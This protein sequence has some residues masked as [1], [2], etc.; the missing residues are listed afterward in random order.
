MFAWRGKRHVNHYMDDTIPEGE[1]TPS[2]VMENGSSL[3]ILLSQGE[4]K[5]E[6]DTLEL[7]ESCHRTKVERERE[8]LHS[9]GVPQQF[10]K[11]FG[12]DSTSLQQQTTKET[13]ENLAST[14]RTKPREVKFHE[15]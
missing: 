13:N 8:R 2:S 5:K 10:H 6:E 3:W 7:R 1:E 14:E 15:E 4:K 11:I 9:H 12:D